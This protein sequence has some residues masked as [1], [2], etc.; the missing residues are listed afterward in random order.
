MKKASFLLLPLAIL[1]AIASG[2]FAADRCATIP[3]GTLYASDGSLIEPGFDQWGYNY[4]AR[5]FNGTYC[6]AYRDA[7]WCQAWKDDDLEMKWNDAWL[8]NRDC[9]GDG[10]LDRHYGFPSY[11]GSGAWLT[12]H[13]K[14]VYIDDNGRKQ[15]WGYFVKI[16]AAPLD[17]TLV[18]GFWCAADG[19][20]IGPT[21]WGDF[22]IIQE[23]VN[24]TGSGDHGVSYLSP[25]GV[26]LGKFGPGR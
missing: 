3:S 2:S 12:N 24:D 13:Q 15:R 10:L 16:V 9:D 11:R 25:Y 26:G 8:S 21:I 4:Q 18:G 19:T 7:D 17:A 6:D 23:V 5:L 14:G 1:C 22:A 20:V